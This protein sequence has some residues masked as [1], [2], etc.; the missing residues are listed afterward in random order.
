[1]NRARGHHGVCFMPYE[2][3]QNIAS[4]AQAMIESGMANSVTQ[5]VVDG[6]PVYAAV[7]DVGHLPQR[8]PTAA[9]AGGWPHYL[10]GGHTAVNIDGHFFPNATREFVVDG[11]SQLPRTLLYQLHDDG[12][13]ELLG[14]GVGGH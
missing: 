8:L 3:A 6:K 12:F 1:M 10:P 11:G 9:D 13:W 14:V 2:D 5:A 7:V 4:P